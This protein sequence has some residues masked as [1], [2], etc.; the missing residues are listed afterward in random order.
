MAESATLTALPSASEATASP[1]AI[2][3]A[4]STSRIPKTATGAYSPLAVETSETQ[5]AL[6]PAAQ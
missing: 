6:A 1:T 2:V 4:A 3:P 5:R